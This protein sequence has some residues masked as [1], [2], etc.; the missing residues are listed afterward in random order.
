MNMLTVLAFKANMAMIQ[1]MS[2][3]AGIDSAK[4]TTQNTIKP[5]VSNDVV[6][7]LAGILAVVCLFNVFK[8]WKKHR[9]GEEFQEN[10]TGVFVTV[11]LIALVLAFNQ[12]GWGM[13]GW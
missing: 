11:V 4:S 12:W 5:V 1:M 2:V 9:G 8:C 7:I 10:V 13:I 6:P 3:V